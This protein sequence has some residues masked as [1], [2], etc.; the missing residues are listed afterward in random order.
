MDKSLLSQVLPNV[1][2]ISASA[3][4]FEFNAEDKVSLYVGEPLEGM[5]IKSIESIQL[6]DAFVEVQSQ[7]TK[8]R[9]FLVYE[10]IHGV[11]CSVE[12]KGS[13]KTGF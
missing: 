13:S 2:P 3:E 5:E 11:G 6:H 4:R 12:S 7:E 8:S 10:A 9:F 1:N